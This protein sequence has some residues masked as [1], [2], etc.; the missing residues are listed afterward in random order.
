MTAA[1]LLLS[2][3]GLVFAVTH[4]VRER[5]QS[6]DRRKHVRSGPNGRRNRVVDVLGEA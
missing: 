6:G 4:N 5:R 1:L 2:L 3:C